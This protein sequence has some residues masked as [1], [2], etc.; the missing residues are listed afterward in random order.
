MAG[1]RE[2]SRSVS[3]T[4]ALEDYS[5]SHPE[6]VAE[7]LKWPARRFDHFY[8]LHQKRQIVAG[9]E[10]QKVE[11]VAA[12]WSNSNWD[13]GKDSRKNAI[14]DIESSY[15]EALRKIESIG[16]PIQDDGEQIDKDNPFFAAAE[17]GIQKL[18]DKYGHLVK[19]EAEEINYMEGLDQ[20]L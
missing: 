20:E 19:N 6:S 11:M 4:E 13:D 18:E 8:L 7:L 14:A 2:G 12:L 3:L 16:K 5:A 10:R 9:L 17:R 15:E 1:S